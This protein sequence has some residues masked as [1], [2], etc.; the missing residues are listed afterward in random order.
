[1]LQSA[2]SCGAELS[3]IIKQIPKGM[4]IKIIIPKLVNTTSDYKLQV[5]IHEHI[6]FMWVYVKVCLV[7]ERVHLIMTVIRVDLNYARK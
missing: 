2:S 7:R 3:Q 6:S 4:I 5:E 1:M